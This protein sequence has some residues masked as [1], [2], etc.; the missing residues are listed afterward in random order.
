DASFNES[1]I[2][3]LKIQIERLKNVKESNQFKINNFENASKSLDKL[4]G[5]QIC[6]NNRKCVGYNAVAPPPT[7]LF[8]PPTIDLSRSSLEEFQQPEFEGY[9]LRANKSD[10]VE[11]PVVVEKKTVVPT[12]PK[13][14]VV[15]PK[16]QE[17]P[18]R[19]RSVM[20]LGSQRSLIFLFAGHPEIELEDSEQSWD[21]R[22][23]R[24]VK[25]T[26]QEVFRYILLVK[27]KLL[28]KKL[29]DSEDEHQV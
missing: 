4:I 16:Q 2:N 27:I 25:V 6:D 15:R 5:S 21:T 18:V 26:I 20:V 9:G 13:V 7:D 29:E 11:S 28:I 24:L 8:V 12:I 14:D 22:K 1:E 19:F 17:K 3:A 23:T 10:E